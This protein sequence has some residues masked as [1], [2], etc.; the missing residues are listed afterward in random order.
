METSGA[1]KRNDGVDDM[2][3]DQ[4]D[5]CGFVAMCALNYRTVKARDAWKSE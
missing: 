3:T 2:L 5:V 4:A 1:A